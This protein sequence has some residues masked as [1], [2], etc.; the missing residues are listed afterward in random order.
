MLQNTKK[1][2]RPA[3]AIS[4]Q[5][6]NNIL[7]KNTNA[8]KLYNKN[9]FIELAGKLSRS[10]HKRSDVDSTKTKELLKAKQIS[11]YHQLQA[12]VEERKKDKA[13][14]EAMLNNKKKYQKKS[15]NTKS[16]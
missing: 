14:I 11:M 13:L 15:K 8:N 4:S 1:K 10:S 7:H 5:S 3:Q 12:L 2:K 6:K 16:F 9:K